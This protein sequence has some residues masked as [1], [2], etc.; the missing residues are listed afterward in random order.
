MIMA[1]A[2]EAWPQSTLSIAI[3]EPAMNTLRALL[4][5]SMVLLLTARGAKDAPAA[6]GALPRRWRTRRSIAVSACNA[7][8][9]FERTDRGMAGHRGLAALDDEVLHEE[10]LLF[11]VRVELMRRQHH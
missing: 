8:D 2:S 10:I 11:R 6:A 9:R 7:T 4:I 1:A 5:G 3:E